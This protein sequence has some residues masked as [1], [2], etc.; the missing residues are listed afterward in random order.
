M[1]HILTLVIILLF[2]G[3]IAEAQNIGIGYIVKKATA[4][5]THSDGPDIDE[6]VPAN[7]PLLAYN[8]MGNVA[9]ILGNNVTTMATEQE[10][11]GRL[12]VRYWKN[13]KDAEA[14]ENTGWV[15]PSAII[16]FP[17]GCC[18]SNTCTGIK[19]VIFQ[20]RTYTDCFNLAATEAIEKQTSHTSNVADIEKMKLELEIE[21]IKLEREKLKAVNGVE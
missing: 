8:T 4:I 20:T 11:N 18:G 12:H 10:S 14:G 16:K 6:T 2:T 1:R 19:A 15:E 7:F 9:A 21:K 5:Y 3:V 13:G 17:F